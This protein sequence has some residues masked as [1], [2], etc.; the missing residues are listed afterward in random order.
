LK[1]AAL[2]LCILLVSVASA[3][4][5]RVV[6]PP[7]K[8]TAPPRAPAGPPLTSGR[9]EGPL[10]GRDASASAPP[11]GGDPLVENGLGSPLCGEA[12]TLDAAARSNCATSGFEAAGVPTGNYGLDVHIETGLLGLTTA[13]VLQDYL[14]EPVWTAIVWIMHTLVVALEWCFTLDLLDSSAPAG[15]ERSLHRTQAVFTGP[16][17]VLV[18]AVASTAAAYNGLVRRRVAETLGQAAL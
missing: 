15:V 16:W 2:T 6:S 18:L 4:A 9:A 8:P 1:V 11:S 7:R 10:F 13:T 12:G 17:L 3:S 14:I 5:S